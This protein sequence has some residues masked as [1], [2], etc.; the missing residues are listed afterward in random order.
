[1]KDTVT[2]STDEKMTRPRLVA[3]ALCTLEDG[4][5]RRMYITKLWL[6]GAFVFSM[7]PPELGTTLTITLYPSKRHP[8]PPIKAQVIGN[9]VDPA[10]VEQSGFEVVFRALEEE[11]LEKLAI[12]VETLEQTL[13]QHV[14][15]VQQLHVGSERR[16]HP[17]VPTEMDAMIRSKTS[18]YDAQAMNISMHG[19]LLRLPDDIPGIGHGALPAALAPGT[20]VSVTIRLPGKQ[21]P[22]ILNA[23][24]VRLTGGAEPQGVGVSFTKNDVSTE[25]RLEELILDTLVELPFQTPR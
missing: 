5:S 21:E 24:I 16:T 10:H 4:T 17:R 11:V 1:M 14:P 2:C 23:Q 12:V 6:E 13:V 18:E 22:M 7:K 25:Q 9:R 15:S 19:A 8:L 3:K 20:T